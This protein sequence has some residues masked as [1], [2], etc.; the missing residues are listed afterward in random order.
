MAHCISDDCVKCGACKETCP[1]QA[2]SEGETKLVVDE[3]LCVDCGAC[4]GVCPTSA[5]QPK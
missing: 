4:E 3:N 2:I 5:I 1:V